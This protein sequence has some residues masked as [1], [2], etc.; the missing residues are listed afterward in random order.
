MTGCSSV[1]GWCGACT[2]AWER[3]DIWHDIDPAPEREDA[4]RLVT[5]LAVED[6]GAIRVFLSGDEIAAYAAWRDYLAADRV[7]R[8]TDTAI[9]RVIPGISMRVETT[10]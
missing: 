3:E 10:R 7:M 2:A 8:W 9:V 1:C 5:V 6:S 4:D